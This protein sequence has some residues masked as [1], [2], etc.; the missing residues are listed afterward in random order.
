MVL[1]N[2]PRHDAENKKF[3]AAITQ[4]DQTLILGYWTYRLADV[5]FDWACQHI[6]RACIAKVRK[7]YIEL[8]N[9]TRII[10]TL[11]DNSR[12]KSTGYSNVQFM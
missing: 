4:P 3:L 9:G 7:L 2:D 10:F 8:V 11:E 1:L 5:G 12:E 6:P